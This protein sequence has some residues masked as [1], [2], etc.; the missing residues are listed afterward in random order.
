MACYTPF[1]EPCSLL[2]PGRQST[3]N[4]AQS[5]TRGQARLVRRTTETK[6]SAAHGSWLVAKL[7]AAMEWLECADNAARDRFFSRAQDLS[8]LEQR[9]RHFEH[10]GEAHY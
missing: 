7:N 2:Q 6:P 10:T 5:A 4:K 3:G 1:Y 9:Q 8:D